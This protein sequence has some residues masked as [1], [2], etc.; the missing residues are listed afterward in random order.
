MIAIFIQL[1]GG[2]L[3]GS[4]FGK[5]VHVANMGAFWN[6]LMGALGGNSGRSVD[7]P[8]PRQDINV[9]RDRCKSRHRSIC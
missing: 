4:V 6:A 2:L 8:R 3:G 9:N 1:I 5:I 7:R